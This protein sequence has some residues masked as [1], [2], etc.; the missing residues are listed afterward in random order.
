MGNWKFEDINE[1]GVGS[2]IM[3]NRILLS[4][5]ILMEQECSLQ[6]IC[7]LN[8]GENGSDKNSNSLVSLIKMKN[9]YILLPGDATWETYENMKEYEIG[10]TSKN[11]K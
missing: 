5:E 8:L 3:K 2:L 6:S 1:V 7:F 10:W 9:E 4:E 11:T